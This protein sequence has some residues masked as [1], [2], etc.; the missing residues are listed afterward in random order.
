MTAV[1]TLNSVGFGSSSDFS[2]AIAAGWGWLWLVLNVAW[3][4]VQLQSD[5]GADAGADTGG[6]AG[7]WGIAVLPRT[8]TLN[9]Y[10]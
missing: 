3:F 9:S 2:R 5:R 8:E 10:L 4:S 6:R 1:S 7:T